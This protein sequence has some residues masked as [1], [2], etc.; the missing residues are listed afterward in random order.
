M[1]ANPHTNGGAL[2]R[3]LHMPDF[4]NYALDTTARSMPGPGDTKVLGAF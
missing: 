2:M 1:G 4:K 3:D